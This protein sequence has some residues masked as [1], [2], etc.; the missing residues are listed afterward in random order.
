MPYDIERFENIRGGSYESSFIF[1]DIVNVKITAKT[2]NELHEEIDKCIKKENLK[3]LSFG[4]M[5]HD[6]VDDIRESDIIFENGEWTVTCCSS[7]KINKSTD[8]ENEEE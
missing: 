8:T 7:E 1:Y 5:Y 3:A 6:D 4:C 2:L